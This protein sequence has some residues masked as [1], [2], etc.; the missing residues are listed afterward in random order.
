MWFWLRRGFCLGSHWENDDRE[1][2]KVVGR[3][4]KP[5]K[6]TQYKACRVSRASAFGA[7]F[8]SHLL[9]KK[10]SAALILLGPSTELFSLRGQRRNSQSASGLTLPDPVFGETPMGFLSVLKTRLIV[11]NTG[12]LFVQL[13]KNVKKEGERCATRPG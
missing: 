2:D 7:Y 8:P 6:K 3:G 13:P 1:I 10:L 5:N 4:R 11:P 9:N 12:L